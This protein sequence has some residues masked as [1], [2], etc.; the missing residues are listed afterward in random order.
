MASASS[1][2]PKTPPVKKQKTLPRGPALSWAITVNPKQDKKMGTW[3]PAPDPQPFDEYSMYHMQVVKHQGHVSGLVHYHYFLQF[4]MACDMFMVKLFLHCDW[5]KC[6][7]CRAPTAWIK[8]L[9]DGHSTIDECQHFGEFHFGGHRTDLEYLHWAASVQ[10]PLQQLYAT[11][12]S[13][14][15]K[16][17]AVDT[18][19]EVFQPG[20]ECPEEITD[21]GFLPWQSFLRDILETPPNRRDVYWFWSL[22]GNEGKSVMADWIE[23]RF[24]TD[25]FRIDPGEVKD[26]TYAYKGQHYVCIDCPRS[27][28]VQYVSYKFLENI[29]NG[30][31][32][33]GKYNSQRRRRKGCAHVVVFAN[34]PPIFEQLSADRWKVFE[35]CDRVIKQ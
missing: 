12:P 14:L 9:N 35:I 8:Y 7:H 33:A 3:T 31:W 1:S 13:L 19:Y 2:Q 11:R 34:S 17:Q 18:A 30:S 32:F 21:N 16:K 29:K 23:F 26:M 5:A 20:Q 10:L 25:S 22:E 28:S 15:G 6:Q 4:K 27:F 24:Q